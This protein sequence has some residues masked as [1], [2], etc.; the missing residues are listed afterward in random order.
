MPAYNFQKQFSPMVLDGSKVHTI[1]RRRKNPTKVGD[2]LMLYT[3]MRTKACEKLMDA[4]CTAVVPIIIFPRL[5][6]VVINGEPLS[7]GDI[8]R[9]AVRDGFA[10]V[11]SF[12][13]FFLRYPFD[14]LRNEMEIIYW[15]K[16]EA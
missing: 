15:R 16:N 13:S 5:P 9:L 6:G 10:D 14:V 1:R 2:A 11:S 3:G 7:Y 4:V 8:E 12:F